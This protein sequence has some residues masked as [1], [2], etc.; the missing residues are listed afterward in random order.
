MINRHE[1]L[2]FGHALSVSKYASIA[3][4]SIKGLIINGMIRCK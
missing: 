4:T 1:A 2:Q 3:R